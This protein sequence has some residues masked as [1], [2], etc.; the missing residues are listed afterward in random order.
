[1]L[2][3]EY[4][5]HV[6]GEVCTHGDVYIVKHILYF[7]NVNMFKQIKI[8]YILD[9]INVDFFSLKSIL[10]FYKFQLFNRNRH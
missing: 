2:Y 10:I 4:S 9:Y 1:M 3:I 6:D 8:N 5:V 7:L